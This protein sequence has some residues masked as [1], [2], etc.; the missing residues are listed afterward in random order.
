M[1]QIKWHILPCHDSTW[2]WVYSVWYNVSWT[3]ESSMHI[4]Q[5]PTIQ[6]HWWGLQLQMACVTKGITIIKLPCGNVASNLSHTPHLPIWSWLGHK[7]GA[8]SIV[9]MSQPQAPE[10]ILNTIK[11]GCKS[12]HPC[13]TRSC[14]CRQ[15][16]MQCTHLCMFNTH[17]FN[18]Y[19]TE[20]DDED[21][22]SD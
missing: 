21:D 3:G 22:Y 8:I 20:C 1:F 6:Q 14:G 9:W 4:L 10:G 15:R 13:N 11:H 5:L 16:N 7:Y 18:M 17:C 12:A 19:T 2:R